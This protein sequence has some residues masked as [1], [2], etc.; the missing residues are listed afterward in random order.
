MTPK[1]III[2]LQQKQIIL[3]IGIPI[4]ITHLFFTQNAKF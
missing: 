2:N 3:D 1:F 4:P